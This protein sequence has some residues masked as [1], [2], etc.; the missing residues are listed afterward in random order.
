MFVLFTIN[1]T[2]LDLLVLE[3][4]YRMK[5]CFEMRCKIMKKLQIKMYKCGVSPLNWQNSAVISSAKM[6]LTKSNPGD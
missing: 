2:S 1:L 4:W 3:Y 5:L 6:S